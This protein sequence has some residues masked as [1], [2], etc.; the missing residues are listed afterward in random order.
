MASAAVGHARELQLSRGG[1]GVIA[2]VL[3]HA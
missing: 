2:D 3:Q 1:V